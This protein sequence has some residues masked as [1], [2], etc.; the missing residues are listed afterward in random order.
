MIGLTRNETAEPVSRDQMLRRKRGQ[1]NFNFPGVQL[2][3]SRIGYHTRLMPSL[4]YAMK[5]HTVHRYYLAEAVK[6]TSKHIQTFRAPVPSGETISKPLVRNIGCST[7]ELHMKYAHIHLTFFDSHARCKN[8]T[9]LLGITINI[10]LTLTLPAIQVVI[11][12][13]MQ[14]NTSLMHSSGKKQVS[15]LVPH[16]ELPPFSRYVDVWW[17]LPRGG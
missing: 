11:Q 17:G 3:T 8:K 10:T 1:G 14:E 6:E 13:A 2:T 5:M 12:S 4:L 15:G 16:Y 9:H 7:W